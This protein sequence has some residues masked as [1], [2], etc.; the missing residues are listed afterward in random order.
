MSVTIRTLRGKLVSA[1]PTGHQGANPGLGEAV[2][3]LQIERNMVSRYARKK[4]FAVH[5]QPQDVR[6]QLIS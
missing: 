1:T 4:H 5:K 3:I 6:K 2:L